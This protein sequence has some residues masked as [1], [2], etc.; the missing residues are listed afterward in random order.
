MSKENS[1][2]LAITD[3]VICSAVE[4]DAASLDGFDESCS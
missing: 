3:E 4:I 1:L 2:E